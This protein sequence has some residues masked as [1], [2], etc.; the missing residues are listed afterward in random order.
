MI[1]TA[2]NKEYNVENGA[3]TIGGKTY[4]VTCCEST[5]PERI[6]KALKGA[7]VPADYVWAGSI[8]MPRIVAEAAL[9]S[10]TVIAG[11]DALNNAIAAYDNA[12]ERYQDAISR[13][14]AHIPAAPSRDAIDALKSQYPIAAAYR[15]AEGYAYSRNCDKAMAGRK[16]MEA[17]KSGTDA[18]Q[19]ITAM[20]SEW[21]QA[22]ISGA[23]N[24]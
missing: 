13:G 11:L 22:A 16:A 21:Q 4:A 1:I 20:E 2:N 8:L 12:Y 7:V 17:I 15:K 5:I 6:I 9:A 3:V 23:Y 10:M 18:D 19:A 24:N 14:A